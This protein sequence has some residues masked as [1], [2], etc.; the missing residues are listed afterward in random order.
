MDYR[1]DGKRKTLA[2]GTYPI[3]SLTKARR[4]RDDA[5]EQIADGIDPSTLKREKKQA[6]IVAAS[7]TFE[8]VAHQWL[9]KTKAKRA[10]SPRRK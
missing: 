6:P 4:K 2:L 10:A 8:V 3:T 9:T 5:R 7:H 1:I